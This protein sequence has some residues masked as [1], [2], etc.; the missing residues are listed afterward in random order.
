MV[1]AEFGPDEVMPWDLKGR[2]VRFQARKRFGASLDRVMRLTR[3]QSLPCLLQE[4]K[5]A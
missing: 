5:P 1:Y 4:G 2:M 3:E